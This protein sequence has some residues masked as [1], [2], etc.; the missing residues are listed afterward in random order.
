MSILY[1]ILRRYIRIYVEQIII[2]LH[3]LKE[4]SHNS[5]RIHVIYKKVVGHKIKRH[6]VWVIRTPD[7]CVGSSVCY[8]QSLL[9]YMC[10]TAYTQTNLS[11]LLIT[12]VRIYICHFYYTI[13]TYRGAIYR[14]TCG[15]PQ[16]T[17]TIIFIKAYR[18]YRETFCVF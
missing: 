3:T 15:I 1:L 6:S 18:Q 4:F 17:I 14:N 5:K 10:K 7:N 2:N 9:R 8:V 16:I 11:L 12:G 13:W